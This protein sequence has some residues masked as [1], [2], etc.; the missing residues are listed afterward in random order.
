[1]TITVTHAKVSAI[2]DSALNSVEM[3]TNKNMV[4]TLDYDTT[5][6]EFAQ[7]DIPLPKSWNNG[8][9]TFVPYW[10]HPATT[11]NFGVVDDI[12]VLLIS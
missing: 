10:S 5:T 8:T 1:M 12:A 4:T 2:P 9:I 3:S 7:V 6:Q 11:T